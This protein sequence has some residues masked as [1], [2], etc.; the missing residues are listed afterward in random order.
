MSALLLT[1]SGGTRAWRR[2]AAAVLWRDQYV[3]R[4]QR[5]GAMCGRPATT[6]NHIT[7]RHLGGCD[8][9][10]N[11]EAACVPCNMG[12]GGRIRGQ[13]M[14]IVVENHNTVTKLVRLLD[15]NRVPLPATRAAALAVI[16]QHSPHPYW[17][18]QID[19]ALH[20]RRA[21]GKLTRV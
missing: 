8:E 21:R 20:Y 18:P 12:A 3:C 10:W 17:G 5:D 11:L 1:A 4:M 19:A 9:M 14:A 13:A 2:I 7:P 6:A 16:R 15:E